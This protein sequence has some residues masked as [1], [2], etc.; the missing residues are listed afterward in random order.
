MLFLWWWAMWFVCVPLYWGG[1]FH[2]IHSSLELIYYEHR[3]TNQLGFVFFV[4]QWR[5]TG[6]LSLQIA[7]LWTPYLLL[8]GGDL[9]LFPL[10]PSHFP[11][12][13]RLSVCLVWVLGRNWNLKND[14]ELLLLNETIRAS[15]IWVF[16]SYPPVIFRNG[17]LE[18]LINYSSTDGFL[19]G[20]WVHHP[21]TIGFAFGQLNCKTYNSLPETLITISSL[22]WKA[23]IRKILIRKILHLYCTVHSLFKI[24]WSIIQPNI[25][26]VWSPL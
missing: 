7:G 24:Y 18:S 25:F 8:T 26:K 6:I 14:N 4:L 10:Y 11:T 1:I 2:V 19:F 9:Q 21:I 23:R 12:I 3:L 15:T 17:D 20:N 16:L 13:A 22:L 5:L